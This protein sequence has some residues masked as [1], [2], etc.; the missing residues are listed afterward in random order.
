MKGYMIALLLVIL[1]ST[2]WLK[3]ERLHAEEDSRHILILNS[4]HK[5][6]AW[7]DDQTDGFLETIKGAGKPH[8]IHV[9]YLDWK[10]HPTDRN[11]SLFLAGLQYKYR[12]MNHPIDLIYATDDAALDFAMKYRRDILHNAPVVF[13]GINRVSLDT[14]IKDIPDAAGVIEDVDPTETI[15][16]ALKITP[17]LSKVY[18]VFDNSESGTSTGKLVQDKIRSFNLEPIPL[19]NL[20]IDQL[21]QF[22]GDIGPDSIILMTTYFSD[23]LGRAVEFDQIAKALSQASNVPVYHLYDFGLHNG[24]FGGSML[25]GKLQ[26]AGAAGIAVRILEGETLSSRVML[27]PQTVRKAFDYEQLKRFKVPLSKLPKDST[28]INK[29]FSFY[30]TYRTLVIAVISAF[31]V[32]FMFI[33]VLFHYIRRIRRMDRRLTA[34]NLELTRL[35]AELSASEEELRL[36]LDEISVMKESLAQSEERFRLAT[37]ASQAVIWD[38][39]LKANRYYYS[40]SWYELSGYERDEIGETTGSLHAIIHPD[41]IP[42]MK[43]AEADHAAG[44]TP[45]FNCELRLRAKDGPYIWFHCKGMGLK[46]NDGQHIRM[47]G[48]LIDITASK[49]YEFKLHSSYQELESTYEELTATQEELQT[50]Y[51][52]LV[53]NQTELHRLAYYDMLC[54]IPNRLSLLF[55]VER[56]IEFNNSSTADILYLD[57]DH[58]KYINDTVGHSAG[59]RLIKKVAERLTLLVPDGDMIFRLGGDEFVI[60]VKEPRGET[61]CYADAL[62]EGF[63]EPI[64]DNGVDSYVSVSIG[65]SRYPRDGSSADELLKNA[66][67][68]M[69]HAKDTG[70]GKYSVYIPA[71]DASYQERMVIEKQLRGAL[72]QNEFV[73]YY[74]PQLHLQSGRITG[75]EALIRWNNPIL[76]FVSPLS[77]IK[78]AEDCRLIGPIGEW[79][80]HKAC[81]F[82]RSVHEQGYGDC[83]ISVNIS[84]IQLIQ[85]EFVDMVLRTLQDEG[86][87]SR[88]LEIEITESVFMESY[89]K[90]IEKLNVLASHGIQIALDDFGTGYSSLSYLMKLPITT[91]KID[92]SFIHQSPGNG[93][94]KS[95]SDS[96]VLIGH[97]IGLHVVAEGVETEEQLRYLNDSGCDSIQGYLISKPLPEPDVIHFLKSFPSNPA[98]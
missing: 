3:T 30:E 85:D 7:T 94:D 70:R 49:E 9:E 63:K 36:Q 28:L 81:S 89:E 48:S 25:S 79:V 88:Y 61:V 64:Q 77:F 80:L 65:I 51:D 84:V 71:M 46:G 43:Q 87:A 34:N 90:V 53:E 33:A 68:A 15:R 57:I 21:L 73:L 5:G 98:L 54:G 26:G 91:L 41:D 86:L 19:N 96:I 22:V 13:S 27:S 17:T 75:F 35:Y 6:L 82:I 67:I 20:S 40:D 18:V 1:V 95:L 44:L 14:I 83:T 12:N 52:A 29:P 31:M 56:F 92:K 59:D 42:G 24:A 78:V 66:D 69:N 72:K 58:F 2:G 55:E 50:N 23:G 76:G 39:D 32:L 97:R 60:L 45:F 4:Y 11:Q 74:Q 10:R 38:A 16:T 62:I 37:D 47:A 93:S 8:H